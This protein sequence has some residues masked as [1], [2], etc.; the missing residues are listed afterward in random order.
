MDISGVPVKSTF[1]DAEK[2]VHREAIQLLAHDADDDRNQLVNKLLPV[3]T[4]NIYPFA[5]YMMGRLCPR[6]AL[7]LVRN[8][9][10]DDCHGC[11]ECGASGRFSW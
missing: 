8:K 6:M 2:F 10:D 3:E 7:C 5:F 9:D 1:G 11:G 4:A